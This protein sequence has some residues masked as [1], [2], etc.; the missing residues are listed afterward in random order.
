MWLDPELTSPYAFRQF[1]Y[2]TDD[3]DLLSRLKSF[4]FLSLEEIE[5]LSGQ[6]DGD[7]NTVRR[8]LAQHMTALVHGEDEAQR[9]ERAAA[10]LFSKDADLN[11]IPVEYLVDAFSGA[12]VTDLPTDLFV[13]DGVTFVDLAVEV[14]RESDEPIS[15]GAARRLIE[16][17]SLALNGR[18]VADP[19]LNVTVDD[20]L[21]GRYLVVR[22]GKRHD[23]LGRVGG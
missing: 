16:Q 23:F 11:Q 13:G 19:F 7:P 5:D 1:W 22:K 4:T 20:L 18:K 12:P 15:K 8:V 9:V 2:N 6:V 3:A 10:V 14:I 21:H 17:N